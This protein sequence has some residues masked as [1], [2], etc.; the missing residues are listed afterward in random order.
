MSLS[1]LLNK[2]K[3][4]WNKLAAFGAW[5]GLVIASFLVPPP[6]GADQLGGTSALTAFGS[7]LV[8]LCVGLIAVPLSRWSRKRYTWPWWKAGAAALLLSIVA[9]LGYQW[10]S[11]SWTCLYHQKLLVFGSEYMPGRAQWVVDHPEFAG[12]ADWIMAHA[13]RITEIWTESSIDLRCVILAAI[14]LLSLPL[15]VLAVICVIQAIYCNS[16][17]S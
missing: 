4:D 5:L 13:G 9:F 15:F 11:S 12:P 16:R 6:V 17:R 3:N 14:Y 1:Q 2:F 8:P 7:F 10:L